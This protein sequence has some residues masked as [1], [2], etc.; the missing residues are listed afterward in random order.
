MALLN[1]AALAAMIN[2]CGQLG[3]SLSEATCSK[4]YATSKQQNVRACPQWILNA[5]GQILEMP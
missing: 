4:A 2:C 3:A 1:E 5:D